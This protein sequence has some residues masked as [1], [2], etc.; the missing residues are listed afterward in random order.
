MGAT[1]LGSIRRRLLAPPT[2]AVRFTTRGYETADAPARE[3]LEFS[4]FQLMLGFEFGIEQKGM[5]ELPIRLESV[6]R[7]H[8]GFAY[9]GAVMGLAVRDALRPARGPKL[10]EAFLAGPDFDSA[11]GTRHIFM[12]YVGIGSALAVLPRALWR[13][14]VP[15]PA[16]L[17]AHPSMRWMIVDGYGFR[18][19]LFEH[20]KYVD[21][22]YVESSFPGWE[23]LDY[24]NRVID[25]GIG[26][27]M[28]FVYGGSVNRLLAGIERFPEPRRADLFSGA[29]I[30]VTNAGGISVEDLEALLKGAGPYRPSLALGAVLGAG[31]RL[32]SDLVVP[33][34]ELATQVLCGCG[35]PE[36]ATIAAS[37]TEDL[38]DASAATYELFRRRVTEHFR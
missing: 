15:D 1:L 23:P 37:A 10:T 17:I 12:S 8:R 3:Y 29:G 20:R 19:G 30:A 13:R 5:D 25:Q 34:T 21:A 16:R 6:Q 31:A 9:E 36:A 24:V 38:P 18:K 32:L 35:V 14:A 27:A 28:W 33:H 26:R 2:D 22:Q 11:P 4:A 7:E